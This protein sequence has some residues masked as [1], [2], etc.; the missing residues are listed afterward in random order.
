ME[1]PVCGEWH[2]LI[3]PW[4]TDKGRQATVGIQSV[5][6]SAAMRAGEVQLILATLC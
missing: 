6:H 2:G 5:R 3:L 1:A 4:R